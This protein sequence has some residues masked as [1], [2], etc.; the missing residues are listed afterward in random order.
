M[1]ETANN[2]RR[3]QKLR[4]RSDREFLGEPRPKGNHSLE[5]A[6]L[7]RTI[8]RLD[9]AKQKLH[10]IIKFILCAA[11]VVR[12]Y[13]IFTRLSGRRRRHSM[14]WLNAFQHMNLQN[15]N[16]RMFGSERFLV[17]K[18][19]LQP[20][21]AYPNIFNIT[22]D[23]RDNFH[24]IVKFPRR[25]NASHDDSTCN[26]HGRMLNDTYDYIVKDFTGK[27]EM[28]NK[29]SFEGKT[30]PQLLP[31]REEAIAHAKA[32]P[33]PSK[34]YDIGRYDEDRQGMYTSSLFVEGNNG[35]EMRR[36]LHV[37]LDIGAPVGTK[38]YAFE[39][40]VVHSV[41]YNPDVGDYGHV[42]VIEHTLSSPAD[43]GRGTKVYALYGHLAKCV[44]NI[45]A[46]DKLMKGQVI[47]RIGN[48]DDNGGWTGAHVHFQ[49]AV[50]PPAKE[51]DMPGTVTLVDRDVALLEYADPRFILG[52]LY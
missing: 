34:G 23:M 38:V 40:G 29:I 43:D 13:S 42:I 11:V 48:T 10:V 32:F 22:Q 47:G 25:M 17:P 3:G 44:M 28:D 20:F 12:G 41:G 19:L 21:G 37:G 15:T 35:T 1:K 30:L 5:V 7:T 18:E 46:G 4:Q 6:A 27:G 51:H 16:G 26:S 24:P 14:G 2:Q 36:T 52:E 9:V 39:D 33:N 50:N 31:S 8:H 45:K 49:V